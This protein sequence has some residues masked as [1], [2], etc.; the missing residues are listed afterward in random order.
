MRMAGAKR[1]DVQPATARIARVH[2]QF[3]QC[4]VV[5]GAYKGLYREIGLAFGLCDHAEPDQFVQHSAVVNIPL[6]DS[7]RAYNS[8]L[9]E[10]PMTCSVFK[11]GCVSTICIQ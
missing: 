7:A 8:K 11:P 3:E 2:R 5:L 4:I 10:A 1:S 9:G 6:G